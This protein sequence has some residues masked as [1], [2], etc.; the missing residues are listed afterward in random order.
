MVGQLMQKKQISS[1]LFAFIDL[2]NQTNF[3]YL[4]TMTNFSNV[5][6]F[7]A[8]QRRTNGTF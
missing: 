4:L 1:K 6:P 8:L 5:H 3:C 2:Q 7:A